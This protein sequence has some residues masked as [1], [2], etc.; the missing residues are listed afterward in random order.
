MSHINIIYCLHIS[1]SALRN[2]GFSTMGSR[3][4]DWD[5]SQADILQEYETG[6]K[7]MLVVGD[8][9]N[10]RGIRPVSPHSISA[11]DQAR[12]LRLGL[13]FAKRHA[14]EL[15]DRISV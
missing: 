11:C 2:I 14:S 12:L 9:S 5:F 13:D 1:I 8:W 7:I 4:M 15:F 3:T 10:P 6:Y